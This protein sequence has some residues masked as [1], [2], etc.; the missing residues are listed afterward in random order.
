M[1]VGCSEKFGVTTLHEKGENA[2]IKGTQLRAIRFGLCR[3]FVLHDE[4]ELEFARG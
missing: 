3:D 4:S 1:A 2:F